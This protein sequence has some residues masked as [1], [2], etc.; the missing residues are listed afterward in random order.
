MSQS[1]CVLLM[2]SILNVLAESIA[3]PIPKITPYFV[4]EI[5][6][7]RS[8]NYLN[9]DGMPIRS[10]PSRYL[11]GGVMSVEYGHETNHACEHGKFAGEYC[12]KCDPEAAAPAPPV[13]PSACTNCG[14]QMR[15]IRLC[16]NCKTAHMMD[17]PSN[18]GCTI[19]R[20]TD[21]WHFQESA[22]PAPVLTPDSPDTEHGMS[23]EELGQ[24]F[25]K[26]FQPAPP[27]SVLTQPSAEFYVDDAPPGERYFMNKSLVSQA[28]FLRRRDAECSHKFDH[29]NICEHCGAERPVLPV[30][31]R[32]KELIDWAS[33][34]PAPIPNYRIGMAISQAF[35]EGTRELEALKLKHAKLVK[36]VGEA[37][38]LPEC[39]EYFH[40][41][42]C[43][44]ASTAMR[45]VELTEKLAVAGRTL[46][47]NRK[48]AIEI[49]SNCSG[50]YFHPAF[51]DAANPQKIIDMAIDKAE[52]IIW[53]ALRESARE[54]PSYITP[55]RRLQ[56]DSL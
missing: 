28:E 13:P 23:S 20:C 16:L 33:E 42:K 43:P 45:L 34:E 14:S 25:G 51:W 48:L 29:H 24:Q 15:E 8:S 11:A 30:P 9:L 35:E 38:C 40:E 46:G 7:P 22:A 55:R 19:N 53:A 36:A 54:A 5:K 56:D 12:E 49:L 37:E 39:D 6:V 17:L 50:Q 44:N 21:L 47:D 27:E 18:R 52:E 10:A 1:N 26:F 4:R 31:T 41:E 2:R 32:I 3:S